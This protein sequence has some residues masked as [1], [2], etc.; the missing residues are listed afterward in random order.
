MNLRLADNDGIRDSRCRLSLLHS[1][2]IGLS[3]REFEG[4][5]CFD[6][7]GHVVEGAFIHQHFDPLFDS[8]E[9]V[10]AAVGTDVVV[11]SDAALEDQFSTRFA[12][13]PKTV[14]RRLFNIDTKVL[15]VSEDR[16][17][18]PPYDRFLNDDNQDRFSSLSWI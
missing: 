18:S 8:E 5:R 14:V 1:I 13:H 15:P 10:L 9:E 6:L 2:A 16:H 12:F 11:L 7:L 17:D 4:I 3:I